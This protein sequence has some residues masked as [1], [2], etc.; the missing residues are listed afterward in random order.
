MNILWT[1]FSK[2]ITNLKTN[3]SGEKL[4]QTKVNLLIG[5]IGQAETLVRSPRRWSVKPCMADEAPPTFLTAHSGVDCIFTLVLLCE[6][7][8]ESSDQLHSAW[9]ITEPFVLGDKMTKSGGLVRL[10]TSRS[11]HVSWSRLESLVAF[12]WLNLITKFLEFQKIYKIT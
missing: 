3:F 7:F 5:H 12:S 9:G 2:F 11:H 8:A 1:N 6:T 10:L 4:C